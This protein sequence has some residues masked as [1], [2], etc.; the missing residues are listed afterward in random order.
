[1][2]KLSVENE[3]GEVLEL[4]DNPDYDVL[5]VAGLNPPAADINTVAVSGMDGTRY[6]SARVGQRNIVITLNINGDIEANRINLYRYFRVKHPVRVHYENEHL[7]VFVD[8]YIDTFENNLFTMLQQPQISIVCPEPYWKSTSETDVNFDSVAPLFEFAF[9]IPA[10]GIAFSELETLQS[11]Y[12]NAGNIETGAIIT[13][14]ALANGV[15]KPTFYNLTTGNFF[16]VNVTM[17][18][19]DII[20]INT[21]QGEKAVTLLRGGVK[22][23]II[24]ERTAGSTWLTFI[25]GENEI[26]F[27]ADEGAT[28]LRVTLQ[29][30]QKYEGV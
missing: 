4:T 11:V 3:Y 17:Q 25:P 22:T 12:F 16:G 14:T 8:G 27:G 6:N 15:K 13:F 30:T 19:G 10:E 18:S 7:D 24:N 9:A 21:Q 26:S 1:V 20:T 23:S 29:S 2:Y 28:S 5:S